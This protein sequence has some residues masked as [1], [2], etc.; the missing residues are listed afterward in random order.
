MKLCNI[1]QNTDSWLQFRKG[2]LGASDSPIIM[3]ESPYKTPFQLWEE[4]T[5]IRESSYCSPAMQRGK[6]LEPVIRERIE[7]LIGKK[8]TPM[9]GIH[10][11]IGYMMSSFDGIDE[12]G[13][14]HEIKC[15]NINDHRLCLGGVV[16]FHYKGQLQHQCKCKESDKVTY[17][18]YNESSE[19]DLAFVDMYRDEAY[20]KIMLN[21]EKEFYECLVNQT[22]PAFCQRDYADMTDPNWFHLAER[23]KSTKSLLNVLEKEEKDLKNT[24]L[25]LAGQSNAVGAGIKISKVITQGRL[26]YDAVLNHYGISDN[27]DQFRKKPTESWR[28]N[29]S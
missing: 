19:K 8:L 20:I 6:D 14:I 1:E 9:V 23:Y 10:D 4:K 15:A 27:L 7:H 28:I 5:G 21:K 12:D 3:L 24:L 16:P 26:D 17:W 18:S 11:E 2:K 22:P 13:N 29:I 25:R